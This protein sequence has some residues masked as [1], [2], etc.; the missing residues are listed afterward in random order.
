[1]FFGLIRSPEMEDLARTLAD[2]FAKQY[3]PALQDDARESAAKKRD[4]AMSAVFSQLAPVRR[5][6]KLG[7]IRKAVLANTLK[8]ELKERGY[9]KDV[10]NA[11]VY[12]ILFWLV[13]KGKE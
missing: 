11:V 8:W 13:Q 6:T 12:D 2:R 4:N 1:M 9:R 7:V 5:T 10:V 3:P